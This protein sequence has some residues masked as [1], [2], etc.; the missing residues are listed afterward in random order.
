MC[1][2]HVPIRPLWR[3]RRCGAPWPCGP[4]RLALLAEYQGNRAAL[5]ARLASLLEEATAHLTELTP[6]TPPGDLT[7]RFL[8]WV[9]APL[10]PTGEADP[11]E[12]A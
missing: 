3:C 10:P 7:N 5:V 8:S 4:A 6:S 2:R 11:A 1:R 9:R 12:R